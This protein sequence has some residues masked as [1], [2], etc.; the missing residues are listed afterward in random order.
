MVPCLFTYYVYDMLITKMYNCFTQVEKDFP[1]VYCI[2]P[3]MNSK[4]NIFRAAPFPRRNQTTQ[5]NT[6]PY[7]KFILLN[8]IAIHQNN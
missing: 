2:N 4:N 8:N 3:I 7:L 6:I 5:N 1:V